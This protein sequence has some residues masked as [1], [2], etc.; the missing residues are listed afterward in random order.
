[1]GKEWLSWVSGGGNSSSSTKT[2]KMA[3]GG[4]MSAV[5]HLFH[6]H[7]RNHSNTY[8]FIQEHPTTTTG[9][10]A[11]RNSLELT[12]E[13]DLKFPVG[14]KILGSK[15]DDVW[16]EC[17]SPGSKTP[18]VVARLMGLDLL[19]Q[20]QCTA[21][22]SR[23]DTAL[24]Q[25]DVARSLPET[26]RTSSSSRKSDVER[27]RLSHQINKENVFSTGRHDRD[28]KSIRSVGL[29][30]TNTYNR[31]SKIVS[32]YGEGEGEVKQSINSGVLNKFP[33]MKEGQKHKE[34]KKLLARAAASRRKD[35]F[36]GS[37]EGT[38]SNLVGLQINC[39]TSPLSCGI[40]N[41]NRPTL[42]QVR[43]GAAKLPQ[44]QS[45]VS[46][47][48]IS[49]KSSTQLSS[50]PYIQL[51]LRHDKTPITISPAATLRGGAWSEFIQILVLKD[52]DS[53]WDEFWGE[54]EDTVCEIEC[55]IV[56]WL[57]DETVA[58]M[59]GNAGEELLF[60]A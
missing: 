16:S 34:S 55:E 52:I 50:K 41:G 17:N 27:H 6:A 40:L 25:I 56:E 10:E 15:A 29:D 5:L 13:E 30:I 7:H 20:P 37:R 9:L 32:N 14:I 49:W 58:V 19:P 42:V 4:C 57:V 39:K 46:N 33:I 3:S 44:K 36:V 2:E 47:A 8:P 28:D 18:S 21:S 54:E 53:Q 59:G 22:P 1:M 26:P 43:N 51:Q 11:P 35:G 23:K 60:V 48:I 38:K 45:Q 24:L 12:Q 31:K